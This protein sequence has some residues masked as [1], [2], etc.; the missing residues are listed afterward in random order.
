MFVSASDIRLSQIHRV[1]SKRPMYD[2][3]LVRPYP[4][5]SIVFASV[6]YNPKA[7]GLTG[8][9]VANVHMVDLHRFHRLGKVARVP[10]NADCISHSQSTGIEMHYRNR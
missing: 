9:R 1:T 3:E 6:L 4:I 10:F 7:K 5:D 2:A 8:T